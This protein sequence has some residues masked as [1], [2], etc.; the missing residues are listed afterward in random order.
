MLDSPRAFEIP[1]WESSVC[2]GSRAV[3][4]SRRDTPGLASGTRG[5]HAAA[6]LAPQVTEAHLQPARGEQKGWVCMNSWDCNL[7]DTECAFV[8][9]G[10]SKVTSFLHVS[11]LQ[12]EK[13]LF[14]LSVSQQ[15][16]QPPSISSGNTSKG[17][18]P[19]PTPC[20]VTLAGFTPT[21]DCRRQDDGTG[22]GPAQRDAP[23]GLGEPPARS[24][25]AALVPKHPLQLRRQPRRWT[26]L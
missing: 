3:G 2:Q 17:D 7:E 21:G 10:L 14:L 20:Q 25:R 4:P 16:F 6:P 13:K 26:M 18:V 23:G 11:A 22:P 24:H 19:A 12:P 8:P 5:S 15:R 9:K 1:K